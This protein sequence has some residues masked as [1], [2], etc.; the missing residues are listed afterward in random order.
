MKVRTVNHILND[1]L[2]ALIAAQWSGG[3]YP[4]PRCYCHGDGS[5][6]CPSCEA[7][8]TRCAIDPRRTATEPNEH[9][10]NCAYMALMREAQAYLD[11]ENT[12][13]KERGGEPVGE[14]QLN[15]I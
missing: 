12:L 2:A 6:C 1:L 3:A 14:S 11:V 15:W 5:P 10:P 8:A 13:A 7:L 4:G 9:K